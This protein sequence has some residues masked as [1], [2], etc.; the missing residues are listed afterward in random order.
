MRIQHETFA[1]QVRIISPLYLQN[2]KPNTRQLTECS[3]FRPFHRATS[4]DA[5]LSQML[6]A[7][8]LHDLMQ[9][10]NTSIARCQSMKSLEL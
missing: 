4:S 7:G 1:P 2:T 9:V 3:E 10:K 5:N 6:H 8:A